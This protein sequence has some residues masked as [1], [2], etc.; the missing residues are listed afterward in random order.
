MAERIG[1]R[2]PWS[3]TSV[4]IS[5][6]SRESK[7]SLPCLVKGNKNFPS[8][9][10]EEEQKLPFKTKVERREPKTS[11]QYKKFYPLFPHTTT[12]KNSKT[13]RWCINNGSWSKHPHIKRSF[14]FVHSVHFTFFV[15]GASSGGFV[16]AYAFHHFVIMKLIRPLG[17][18]LENRGMSS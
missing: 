13:K 16:F 15:G 5:Y 17:V 12:T 4:K 2:C 18:I 3:A 7:T 1:K 9:Q 14:S 10:N 11:L 6:P 8:P